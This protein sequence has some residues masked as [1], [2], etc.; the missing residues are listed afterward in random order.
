[1]SEERPTLKERFCM[2]FVSYFGIR[3]YIV[4]QAENSLDGLIPTGRMAEIEAR[5][6]RLTDEVEE[7]KF[8]LK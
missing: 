3:E 6:S 7:L 8:L 2:W 5:I 1:V 4:Q